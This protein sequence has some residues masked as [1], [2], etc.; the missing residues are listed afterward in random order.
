MLEEN[1]TTTKGEAHIVPISY[2][3]AK[4]PMHLRLLEIC[5]KDIEVLTDHIANGHPFDQ[6][7]SYLFQALIWEESNCV[8]ELPIEGHFP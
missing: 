1:W 7:K 4:D 2:H 5:K 3:L 6:L 8:A